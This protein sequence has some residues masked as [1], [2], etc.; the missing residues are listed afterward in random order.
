M[1]KITEQE[2]MIRGAMML[3]SPEDREAF[4]KACD[5]IRA[6]IRTANPMIGQIALSMV[7]MEVS[8]EGSE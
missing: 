6:A 3:A 4:L 2:L 8:R 5:D 1:T 7:M